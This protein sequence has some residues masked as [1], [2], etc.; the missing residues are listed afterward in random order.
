M[1]DTR[2][3][4]SDL[5]T[6]VSAY[7]KLARSGPGLRPRFLLE[8]VGGDTRDGGTSFLGFGEAEAVRLELSHL[9]DHGSLDERRGPLLHALRRALARAPRLGG[10]EEPGAATDPTGSRFRGGL[11]GASSFSLARALAGLPLAPEDVAGTPTGFLGLA[12]H[13]VLVFDH[14]RARLT[15][16]SSTTGEARRALEDEV[17][18][19]LH[20]PLAAPGARTNPCPTARLQPTTPRSSFLERVATAQRAIVAGEI[21]Q[22]VLSMGFEASSDVPA[23]DLYRALRRVDPSPYL[24]LIHLE[25][26]AIVGA[27]PEALLRVDGREASVQPIAGT[28]PRGTTRS[29]DLALER[30]LLADPK[31][32]AEHVM[33]VD[34]ARSDLGRVARAGTVSVAPF[35]EV[36]RF[37]EVM[38]LVSGVRS[39]LLGARDAFDAFCATFPAGTVVGAPRTRAMEWIGRLEAEP[40]GFYGGAVG[41][42]GHGPDGRPT[43]NQAIAIRTAVLR[44]GKISVRAGAGIVRG[45]V[46]EREYEEVLAKTRALARALSLAEGPRR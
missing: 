21:Y 30:E 31:E 41:L 26:C 24:F 43:A 39:E 20:R 22:V 9:P 12:P 6:P 46:P 27:S 15:L 8:S 36:H 28:R 34:M 33:L 44:K 11:V 7:L 1:Q 13:H 29:L 38:H 25:E 42:F 16:E 37:R 45:S 18:D 2:D 23:I 40:R 4:P 3:F 10:G 17:L 32:A 14:R 19:A 35:R 5:E